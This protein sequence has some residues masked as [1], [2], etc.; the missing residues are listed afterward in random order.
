KNHATTVPL[1]YDMM[2]TSRHLVERAVLEIA[3]TIDKD[4]DYRYFYFDNSYPNSSKG[5]DVPPISYLRVSHD[6]KK[7][8][9]YQLTT[10]FNRKRYYKT[11]ANTR[12]GIVPEHGYQ[13][14]EEITIMKMKCIELRN[15]VMKEKYVCTY[16]K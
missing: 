6:L 7:R 4:K 14:L 1:V 16:M 13:K 15:Y 12:M 5:V 10:V 3:D 9:V 8:F 11:P 2:E